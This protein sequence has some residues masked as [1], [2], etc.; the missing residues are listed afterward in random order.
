[1]AKTSNYET[2]VGNGTTIRGQGICRSVMVM[3][4][5]ITIVEVFLQLDLGKTDV[6]LGMALLCTTSFMGVHWPTLTTFASKDNQV[7]LKRDPSLTKAEVNLKVMTKTWE[8]E[9]Q[10]FLIEF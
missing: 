5:E 4:S 9:D 2:V 8:V 10:G 1:M 3:L 6:I 7:K